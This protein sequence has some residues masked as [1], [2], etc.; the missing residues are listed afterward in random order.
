MGTNVEAAR[1]FIDGFNSRDFDAAV[2]SC[3]EDFVLD[4]VPSGQQV[5]GA[6]GL[7]GWLGMWGQAFGDGQI[8]ETRYHDAGDTVVAEAVYEGTNDG[9]FGSSP[10]SGRRAT[11]SYCAVWDFNDQ[12]QMVRQAAY[13]DMA[14][15][16][17]QLSPA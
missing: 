15:L 9:P 8:G 13:Y 6:E 11:V 7:K 16:M 1:G 17:A 2:S 10:A 12:G 4:D 3:S 5:K 14:G